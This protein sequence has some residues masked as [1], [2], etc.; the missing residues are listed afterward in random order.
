MSLPI[1]PTPKPGR[2]SALSPA[3]AGIG[4]YM[5]AILTMA[6]MDSAAKGLS[7]QLP[8]IQVLWARYAGQTAIVL[9]IVA[10]RLATVARTRH[11]W[12]Q[13]LRSL[14][15]LAASSCFF[16]AISLMGLAEATAIMNLNPLLI[17]L[18]AAVFLGERFGLRRAMGILA[19]LIGALIVIRPGSEV[20]SPAAVLPLIAAFF[21]AGFALATRKVGRREDP[22]TSLFYAALLGTAVLSVAVVPVWQRPDGFGVFLMLAVGALGALGQILVIRALMLAEASAVAPFSYV[23]LIFAALWGA[24]FFGEYPDGPTYVG[25]GIIVSAGLYVWHRETRDA[26]RLSAP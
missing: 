12:L 21:Y 25:A 4:L 13:G 16:L 19:A 20:F 26:R 1:A 15:L 23:G 6:V 17:T 24:L 2:F 10:P 18:G 5:V 3:A 9:V 7:Q 22:M 11:P 14:F 8:V